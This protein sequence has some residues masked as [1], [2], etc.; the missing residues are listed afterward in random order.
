MVFWDGEVFDLAP[1]PRVVL[2]I[3]SRAVLRAFATARLDRLE[4]RLQ[5]YREVSGCEVYDKVVSVGMYEHVGI[6]NL[7]RYF[8]TMARLLKPQAWPLPLIVDGFRL[9]RFWHIRK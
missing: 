1:A 2:S 5:D 6:R 3:R 7:P 8:K 9:L 4:V